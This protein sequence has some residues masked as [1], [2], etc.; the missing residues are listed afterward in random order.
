MKRMTQEM[1]TTTTAKSMP[2]WKNI[3]T[4]HTT[5]TIYYLL[6]THWHIGILECLT[7]FLGAQHHSFLI[8]CS[9]H[10]IKHFSCYA[11]IPDTVISHKNVEFLNLWWVFCPFRL[12]VFFF[13]SLLLS[14]VFFPHNKLIAKLIYANL[15]ILSKMFFSPSSKWRMW[16]KNYLESNKKKWWEWAKKWKCAMYVLCLWTCVR[17]ASHIIIWIYIPIQ[18]YFISW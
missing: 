5:H 1:R 9:T 15:D 6:F 2:T 12:P 13:F 4:V 17:L 11:R 3:K 8:V 7:S 14:R 18:K 16:E 10:H